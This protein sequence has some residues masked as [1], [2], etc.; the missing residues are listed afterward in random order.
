MA[1]LFVRPPRAL[2]SSYCFEIRCS[3]SY[4]NEVFGGHGGVLIDA[5]ELFARDI[6]TWSASNVVQ[7]GQIG[8]RKHQVPAIAY[9]RR[10][11]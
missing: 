1:T 9:H 4:P 11:S 6:E 8:N 7:S 5:I 3:F 10:Q 2:A